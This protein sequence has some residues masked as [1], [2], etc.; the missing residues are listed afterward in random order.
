MIN[1][2]SNGKPAVDGETNEQR[3]EHEARNADR[4]QHRATE[5]EEAE[6]Q[7]GP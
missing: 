6:R 4:A 3:R 7:G 2:V 1:H 5:D